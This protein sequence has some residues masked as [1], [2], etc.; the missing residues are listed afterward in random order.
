MVQ[1]LGCKSGLVGSPT[2]AGRRP[3]FA[4]HDLRLLQSLCGGRRR[5]ATGGA[6]QGLRALRQGASSLCQEGLPGGCAQA[7]RRSA[8]WSPCSASLLGHLR[9]FPSSEKKKKKKTNPRL[10]P[11]ASLAIPPN[12]A[13]SPRRLSAP[14]GRRRLFE[15]AEAAM[16]PLLGG[17]LASLD[18]AELETVL[19]GRL[20]QAEGWGLPTSRAK[21]GGE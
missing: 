6:A 12:S 7:K 8:W 17:G 11:L 2:L 21:R 13:G 18:P 10:D 4:R 5:R 3:L 1:E 15:E 19:K 14:F 16:R 20:H 9:F